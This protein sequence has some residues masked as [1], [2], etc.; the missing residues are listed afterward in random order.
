[1]FGIKTLQDC[2]DG[3]LLHVHS[4]QKNIMHIQN[5][6]KD[7]DIGAISDLIAKVERR[8]EDNAAMYK[9]LEVMV[10]EF[11]GCIAMSR[12]A[13]KG[14]ETQK[15]IETIYEWIHKNQKANKIKR[16][17]VRKDKIEEKSKVG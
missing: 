6:L 11:K 1:M 10:N 9:K 7:Y 12:A 14:D 3:L 4:V 2:V 8:A 5:T 16:K 15:K 17:Y 13:L